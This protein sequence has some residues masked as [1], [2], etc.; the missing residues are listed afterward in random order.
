MK[1]IQSESIGHLAAIQDYKES[2]QSYLQPSS[3]VLTTM[4]PLQ[5]HVPILGAGQPAC[6]YDHLQHPMVTQL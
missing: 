1:I 6:I 4:P 3:R 2:P 5:S